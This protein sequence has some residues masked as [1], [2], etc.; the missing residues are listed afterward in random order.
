MR[1][2][3]I[4]RLLPALLLALLLAAAL[5]AAQPAPAPA[6][7]AS[8]GV[9]A[10]PVLQA[11][12]TPFTPVN[13]PGGLL[14]EPSALPDTESQITSVFLPPRDRIELAQR[15]L[16]VTVIPDPPLSP[17]RD[18]QVGDTDT[19]WVDD[20]DDDTKFE[21]QATLVYITDHAYFW[22]ETGYP[23]DEAALRRSADTFSEHT[24]PTVRETFGSEWSPG[25]D[26]DPRVYILHT[27]RM[28]SGIAGY[29]AS[30]S[31]QPTAAVSTSNEH[32]M[33]FINLDTMATD[34]GT[35]Y[36]DGVLAHEFQHMIHWN[37]D[38]NE[39]TWMGE[40]LSELAALLT[41]FDRRGFAS[42]YLQAPTVQ[43]NA[44]PDS[45]DHLQRYGAAF[46]FI[47]Y[48]HER[49]GAEA[50]RL[51]VAN[52]ANGFTSIENTLQTLAISD[53]L[54]GQ[55][56]DSADVFADWLVANLL[57]DPGVADGRY[58]YTLLDPALQQATITE[59]VEVYPYQRTGSTIAQYSPHYLQLAPVGQRRVRLE[60][61]GDPTVRLVPTDAHSG[62]L[63]WYGN[64]GDASDS[65][66]TRAFDL[67]GV[68]KASLE[69]D[70][71]YDLE[72]L[73]DYA[74]V[75][76]SADDGATWDILPTQHTTDDNPHNNAYGPGFTGQSADL[77]PDGW[78]H[79]V[80]DLSAYIGGRVL[81]RFEMIT[82]EATNQP[83]LVI[84]DVIVPELNYYEDFEKGPGGWASEGWLLI[85]N[86]LAQRWIVQA[87]VQT[88]AGT[89]VERLLSPEDGPSGSWTFD[90]GG[91]AGT[92][93]LVISPLAPLTTEPGTYSLTVTP[94]Q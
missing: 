68:A 77:S 18:W 59:R 64:R 74:Y 28:G 82:D 34:F 79:E 27:T 37:I 41:G 75:M 49:Y 71:W 43:L 9:L 38:L 11:T 24:Y 57:D 94:A 32:E 26:G 67:S 92:V 63:M 8:G 10:R 40:G 13:P 83:G 56:V 35:A 58:T 54:T 45:N 88:P 2:N 70:A 44:W 23:F 22:V 62:R 5:P 69:F 78:L 21:M 7:P 25:I 17:A 51:L 55:P 66:L 12:P 3:P 19:F 87:V 33:F 6:L 15:L 16:G 47:T 91:P 39:E 29:F 81:V 65:R 61:N 1:K 76:V 80:A 31:E 86:V 85:D 90:V 42:T 46:L 73:W 4:T 60:F 84:D 89:T 52:P 48:F 36:Y 20:T 14:H 50:T 30:E 72:S 93:T 53:P